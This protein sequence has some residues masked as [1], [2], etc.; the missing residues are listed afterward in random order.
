MRPEALF[1][2]DK[3]AMSIYGFDT[4]SLAQAIANRLEGAAASTMKNEAGDTDIRVKVAHGFTD[5][6]S[7]GEMMFRSP[8]GA[9]VSLGTLAE[10]ELSRGPR[11]IVRRR[12]SECYVLADL[13]AVP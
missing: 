4:R 12:Q 9:R 1:H 11:E 7:L 2:L 10:I 3:T 8:T 5:V 6:S 13:D